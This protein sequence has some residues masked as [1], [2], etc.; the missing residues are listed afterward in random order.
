MV[1]IDWTTFTLAIIAL[2]TLAGFFKGWW[3]EAIT[4]GFLIFLLFLLNTPA[5]AQAVVDLVNSGIEFVWGLIPGS[6]LPTVEAVVNVSPGEVPYVDASSGGT[7]LIALMFAMVLSI[8]IA[9]YGLSNYNA[10][11]IGSILGGLLGGFNGFIFMGLIREYLDGRNLPSAS[12]AAVVLPSEI[13]QSAGAQAVAGS[14]VAFT[15]TNVP[16]ITIMDSYMPWIL[17]LIGA[18]VLLMALKNRVGYQKSSNGYRK[19]TTKR[20]YGYKS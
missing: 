3:K 9:R 4:T 1:E 12:Q 8:L 10:S 17:M 5:A 11:P 14:G 2:F 16:A 18:G 13:A 20:P 7:W 15:A 19:F 6:I